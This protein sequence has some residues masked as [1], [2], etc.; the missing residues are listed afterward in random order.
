MWASGKPAWIPDVLDD[1]NFPRAPVASHARLHGAFGFPILL[2]GES[3]H[4]LRRV[5]EFC[6]GWFPRP[7]GFVAKEGVARLKAMA[8][9]MGRDFSTLS[10][11]VFGAPNKAEA[12][13][14]AAAQ[15]QHAIRSA[16]NQAQV[17]V[18]V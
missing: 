15:A 1:P 6:D 5:V 8:E 14:E 2:G 17:T 9:K 11:T 4:T 10:I 12:L 18:T 3:D 16:A 7:R 13:A